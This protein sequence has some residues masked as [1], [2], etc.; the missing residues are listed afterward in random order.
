[1]LILIFEQVCMSV[2][3]V[4]G[5]MCVF[6]YVYVGGYVC[7]YSIY[8]CECVGIWGSVYMCLWL[9]LSCGS[10]YMCEWVSGNLWT[11]WVCGGIESACEYVC[12]CVVK[13]CSLSLYTLGPRAA[14]GQSMC[15]LISSALRNLHSSWQMETW[16]GTQT[17][18][19]CS[20]VA[21]YG[22]FYGSPSFFQ[23]DRKY[24]HIERAK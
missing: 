20:I 24:I 16:E 3:C 5:C 12:T 8:E 10:V 15:N 22:A 11:M 21:L 23:V 9:Y 19:V 2:L 13:V 6:I 7:V 18:S 1:M 14:S 17:Y 4:Y